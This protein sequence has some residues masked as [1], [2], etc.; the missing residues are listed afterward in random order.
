MS[1]TLT[2]A[3]TTWEYTFT[4][5]LSSTGYIMLTS[6]VT[7]NNISCSLGEASSTMLR[8][9]ITPYTDNIQT[10]M[11]NIQLT[12]QDPCHSVINEFSNCIGL[13]GGDKSLITRQWDT[14]CVTNPNNSTD[15]CLSGRLQLLNNNG[16][17][18]IA[19]TQPLNSQI[20]CNACTHV[21]MQKLIDNYD[22]LRN[23]PM[24]AS[25]I[26]NGNVVE[27]AKS[28]IKQQCGKS[29]DQLGLTDPS[30]MAPDSGIPG[31]ATALIVL[32]ILCIII[33]AVGYYFHKQHKKKLGKSIKNDNLETGSN[34][35]RPNLEHWN[36]MSNLNDWR[37]DMRN[38]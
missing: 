18:L 4:N 6:P 27:D 7:Y 12:C 3:Q 28:N 15:N 17:T 29:Y 26:Q 14:L 8:Q 2:S 38:K 31:W 5:I 30:T 25:N 20:D 9:C 10:Q 16:G 36:T 11:N 19:M 23:N 21:S 13:S 32:S 34:D 22:Y 1:S 35:N 37:L 24:Y 33:A